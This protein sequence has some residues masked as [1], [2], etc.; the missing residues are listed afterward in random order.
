MG[1]SLRIIRNRDGSLDSIG[2][3]PDRIVVS[4][5]YVAYG[6]NAAAGE[7]RAHQAVL[8]NKDATK[9]AKAEAK[10]ALAKIANTDP[11]F[12]REGGDIIYPF[13]S[14]DVR[15]RFVGFELTD[16]GEPNYGAQIFER[17]K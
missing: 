10:E 13:T 15:Y 5:R 3:I 2:E 6:G 7:A 8:D 9:A 1:T 4:A 14:G 17:V 11:V 12:N 16:A